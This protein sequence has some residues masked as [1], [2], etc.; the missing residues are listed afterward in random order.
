MSS[1]DTNP[2][3]GFKATPQQLRWADEEAYWR[4]TWQ[5]RPYIQADRGF[6][7]Y[8]PAYRYGYEA[9]HRY[10]D[11]QWNDVEHDLRR[12]WDHYEHR[13]ETSWH[14]I[15]EAVRDAWHRVT[16]R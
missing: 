16:H 11:R 6:E 15:K 3:Q 13:G 1:P 9:A 8:R 5:S 12:D 10:P 14:D 4:D 7:L 2:T